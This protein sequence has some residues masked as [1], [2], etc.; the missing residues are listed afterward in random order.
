MFTF[1]TK[2]SLKT[3]NEISSHKMAKKSDPILDFFNLSKEFK[4]VTIQGS[5]VCLVNNI[6]AFCNIIYFRLVGELNGLKW[7]SRP[8]KQMTLMSITSRS[9]ITNSK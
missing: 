4:K 2:Y 9:T 3:V 5:Q 6:F 7:T 1:Q 8:Q